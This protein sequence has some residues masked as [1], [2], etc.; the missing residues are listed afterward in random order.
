VSRFIYVVHVLPGRVRLRLPWLR[1]HGSVANE[2]AEGLLRIRGV[3]EVEVR[4]FTGSVLVLHD[5][6]AL[7]L[8]DVL[9][10]VRRLTGVDLVVRQGEEAPEEE[11]LLEALAMGSDVALATSRF[12]K[13]LDVEVLRATGGKVDL[14]SLASLG[15]AVA[16]AAKVIA[17]KKLPTPDWFNLAWWAFATFSGVERTAIGNTASP[18]RTGPRESPSLDDDVPAGEPS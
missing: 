15:F 3:D 6:E 1:E 14:G 9:A 8:E 7:D 16:G 17:T 13:G 12:V 5:A 2:L 10:M 18:V 4:P 11:V